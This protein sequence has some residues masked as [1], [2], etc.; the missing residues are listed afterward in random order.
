MPLK[1]KSI[2][3]N[4]KADPTANGININ[5]VSV[6][7]SHPF[8]EVE[9]AHRDDFYVFILQQKGS[10]TLEIDFHNYKVKAGS[11]VFIHPTQVHRV[12][13]FETATFSSWAL[14]SEQLN[15]EYLSLLDDL[16]AVKP[17]SLNKEIYSLL[18]EAVALSIKIFERKNQKMH[19]SILKESCNTLVGVAISQLL[20]QVK[21]PEKLSRFESVTKNFKSILEQNFTSIKSPSEYAEKLNISTPYLNECVKSATGHSVSFHIQERIMLEAKRLLYHSSKSVKEISEVLGYDDYSYFIRTFS[22]AVKQSPL[23]FRDKT[24][25]KPILLQS[26]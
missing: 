10:M 26:L 3:V 23:A 1:T 7:S 2:P 11:I 15:P 22:K 13:G 25:N 9:R 8:K 14:S 6:K 12:I 24:L 17:L 5:K 4:M 19:V 21:P 18:S 20:E 16:T